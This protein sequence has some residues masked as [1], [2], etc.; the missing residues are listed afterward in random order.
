MKH[1]KLF[2]SESNYSYWKS[3]EEILPNISF[4]DSSGNVI[5]NSK[6]YIILHIDENCQD[7]TTELIS[8]WRKYKGRSYFTGNCSGQ[9]ILYEKDN[10]TISV[11]SPDDD[12]EFTISESEFNYLNS[13][14]IERFGKLDKIEF[15]NF[16]D[17]FN[18][19]LIQSHNKLFE[20]NLS[21]NILTLGPS[22][23]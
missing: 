5:Y 22:L 14:K 20:I 2:D 11:S 9:L 4:I 6:E 23:G 21:D 19:I 13:I 8:I 16:E 1:L 3:Q 7:V 10:S 18:H 17:E 12:R 15:I